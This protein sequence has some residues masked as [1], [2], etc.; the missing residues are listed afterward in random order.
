MILADE[1]TCEI[2]TQDA[3]KADLI[4][5]STSLID[6]AKGVELLFIGLGAIAALVAAIFAARAFK[7][8]QKQLKLGEAQHRYP[9]LREILDS[10]RLIFRHDP[11]SLDSADQLR[12]LTNEANYLMRMWVVFYPKLQNGR[13]FDRLFHEIGAYF[14]YL[15]MA[16]LHVRNYQP[17]LL[18]R[19]KCQKMIQECQTEMA[20][21]E[22]EM[23]AILLGLHGH[24]TSDH[25]ARDDFERM[26]SRINTMG[27][28]LRE[29][30]Y[31]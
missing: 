2:A 23:T 17:N 30:Q 6:S 9:L 27:V 5:C 22:D 11:A 16:R 26:I 21:I 10:L 28:Q 1:I 29:L 7:N 19:A 8:A 3:V 14:D 31:L 12:E 24:L 13:V 18:K 25:Q 20:H 4:N 15:H